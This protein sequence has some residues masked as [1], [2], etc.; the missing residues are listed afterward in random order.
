MNIWTIILSIAAVCG[1]ISGI[2]VFL[3][4]IYTVVKKF[5]KKIES[6]ETLKEQVQNRKE[7]NVV[8]IKTLFA[9]TD[10][11]T[12]LGANGPVTKARDELRDYVIK[13]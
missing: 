7:E 10:G 13:N 11:L 8:I 1:G 5:D 3:H 4:K 9:V 12:Q 6:V 2:C